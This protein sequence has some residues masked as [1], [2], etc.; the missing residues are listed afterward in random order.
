MVADEK[1]NEKE[2]ESDDKPSDDQ[3]AVQPEAKKKKKVEREIYLGKNIKIFPYNRLAHLDKGEVQAYAA[4]GLNRTNSNLFALVCTKPLTPRRIAAQKY[5]NIKSLSLVRL[6][7]SGKVNWPDPDEEKY[8][9][10]YELTMGKALLEKSD[11][12]PALSKKPEDIMDSI[13]VP[14]IDLL[15]DLANK[16]LVHGEIW[17]G[18]IFYGGGG[19]G[20]KI[21]LGECLSMPASTNLP[22]LY[23][24]VERALADPEGKGTGTLADDIYSLGVSLAV[25]LRSSTPE[26]NLS[27]DEI[28]ERKIEKGTYTTLLKDDRFSGAIL[29]LLRGLLY[30]DPNQRW[31]LEDIRAWQDGR[32]LSP[33]QF[34]PRIKSNRPV[35]M[36]KK[37]Y[38]RPELLAKDFVNYPLEAQ[39]IVENDEL[40]Q[41]IDRA[42][43]DKSL[44]TRLEQT[45]KESNNLD[46]GNDFSHRLSVAVSS[47]LFPEMPVLY[48]ELRFNPRGFGKYLTYGYVLKND[49]KPYIEAIRNYFPTFIIR[50]QK[51]H[52]YSAL[53]SKFDGAR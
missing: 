19:I 46:Q 23:E 32:R 50:S 25:I 41:W 1:L 3:K 18:N 10:V 11:S 31:T 24:P 38:V 39:K 45:V 51:G 40:M 2:K 43:E 52:D 33:K 15:E 4:E 53:N 7:D 42:I 20:D 17:P 34:S 49:I 29:E 14:M 6:V 26:A 5:G 21:V 9:F 44:K 47:V 48:K 13:V 22:A 28:L 37:K 16:D 8:C 36:E 30:D 35:I 12:H 27:D